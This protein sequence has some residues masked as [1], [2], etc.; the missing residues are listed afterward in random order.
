[1]GPKRK[2]KGKKKSAAELEAERL[3]L[4][5]QLRLEEE[6]RKRVEEEE[7]LKQEAEEAERQRLQKLHLDAEAEIL[8]RERDELAPL[9]SQHK[10]ELA[11][12][13]AERLKVRDWEHYLACT[14]LPDAMDPRAVSNFVREVWDEDTPELQDS[15]NLSE[16]MLTV[17]RECLEVKLM[18]EQNAES[19]RAAEAWKF[20]DGLQA[21]IRHQIDRASAH[22]LQHSD[23]YTPEHTEPTN[24]QVTATTSNFK[25]GLWINTSKNPRLKVADMSDLGILLEMP[26]TITLQSVALRIQRRPYDDLFAEC[27][28]EFAAVGGLLVV[29]LLALPPP[30]KV[31]KGWILRQVT[32]ISKAVQRLPY[33]IPPAGADPLTYVPTED[34]PPLGLTASLAPGLCLL[35]S[36]PRIGWW[37]HKAKQWKEDG[38]SNVSLDRGTGKLSLQTTRLAPLA[39]IQSRARLLPYRGWRVRPCA[40]EQGGEAV[41]SLEANLE[42]PIQFHVTERA[43]SLLSPTFPCLEDL[44]RVRLPPRVL[45]ARLMERGLFLMPEDRDAEYAKVNPKKPEVEAAACRDMA[46]LGDSFLLASCKWNQ[47]A[48]AEE[49]IARIH[50]VL[51]WEAG[52]RTEEKHAHRIFSKEKEEGPRKV[53]AIIQR[54]TKGCAF[55]DALES[56]LEYNPLPEYHSLEYEDSIYGECHASVLTLLRGTVNEKFKDTELAARLS[57][58][59]ESL[60]RARTVNPRFAN[61]LAQLMI[62]LRLFSFG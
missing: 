17:F 43:T 13:E 22:V 40:G 52:G 46:L 16:N 58:T 37:D 32:H 19:E 57:A 60:N 47:F 27:T 38:I 23:M 45:L 11:N 49:C 12:A 28:N 33:P 35:E 25:A 21:A 26:K 3:A 6:E 14:P 44:V 34:P 62:A 48:G 51:D 61:T 24:V 20:A 10:K 42:E 7:R 18:A 9:F 41:I 8:K 31:V 5:E 2:K 1:M 36:E 4:E 53:M 59:E 54:G 29:D 30:C 55:V 50:E 39:V 56:R 15:L